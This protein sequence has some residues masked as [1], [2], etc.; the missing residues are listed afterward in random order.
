MA[1]IPHNLD[2]EVVQ[3]LDDEESTQILSV[4]DYLLVPHVLVLTA[5]LLHKWV[6]SKPSHQKQVRAF[7][8][9]NRYS[10]IEA[11]VFV[12]LNS[13]FLHELNYVLVER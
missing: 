4:L 9:T 6:L 12:I 5:S 10:E 2:V 13:I 7:T 1:Q 3:S 8:I 11:D